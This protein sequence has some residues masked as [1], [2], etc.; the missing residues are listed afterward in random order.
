MP[1][2]GKKFKLFK[3]CKE[4]NV[5][6]DTIESFLKDKGVKVSGPN[7]SISAE[8]HDEILDNFAREKEIADKLHLR[9]TQTDSDEDVQEGELQADKVV[10]KSEYIQNIERSIEERIESMKK[11]EEEPEEE[12]EKISGKKAEDIE[13]EKSELENELESQKVFEQA[14]EIIDEKPTDGKA[15]DSIEEK[16]AKPKKEKIRTIDLDKIGKIAATPEP[17][18]KKSETEEKLS[19]KKDKTKKKEKTGAKEAEDTKEAKRRKALE[20]IRKDEK[21]RKHFLKSGDVD[22]LDSASRQRQRKQKKKSVDQKEVQ[23][24][25]KKTLAS[26]DEKLRKTKKRKKIKDET[27]EEIEQNVI[28]ASEFISANDLANLMDVPVGEIIKKCLELGLVVSINQ[29]LDIDTIELL[30]GE[31]DYTVLKEEEYASDLIEELETDDHDMEDDEWRPP[32][33]TIMGHVDHGKTSLLDF[34]RN[35]NVV[36]GESGGITQHIGAYVVEKDGKKI[37]FLDTPGHEAFTAMRARGAQVTDIVILVVAADDDVMPQT[38]EA[39]DHV[40][41]AGVKM[42]I[43]INKTDRP[44]AN[45]ERI[46][47]QLAERNILVEDWGGEYQCALIS[48]KTGQG[49]DELLEKVLIESELLDL[50]A[51]SKKK[52]KGTVIESLLDKG[53]G[54]ISTILVQNGTLKIG[55]PFIAGQYSGKVRALLDDKDQRVKTAHPSQPVQVLGFDGL[56]QAGDT[57]FVMSDE[58]TVKEI[59]SRRQRIKREQDYRQVKLRTLDQ[60]SENIKSGGVKELRIIVKADVD[61]SAEALADSLIKISKKEV[62]V[63]VI[64]KAVGPISESDVLLAAASDAI[65][66]GFHV[67][68]N[69]KAKELAQQEDIEIRNYR[70]VYDA[71]NDVRLALEGMLETEKREEVTGM[72][73]IRETFKIS[74][75][76]TIAGCHVKSGKISRNSK[77]RL[78]R[79]DVNVY[80]GLLTSLKRF[81]EDVKEVSSGFECGLQIQN[82]N[83]IKVG[84]MIEAFEIVEHKR[85]LDA[86]L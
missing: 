26:I 70:V 57:F 53:K 72:V 24:T 86:A 39:I 34:I 12:P 17:V 31:W 56:P 79:D 10:E 11:K 25:V 67:R 5:G 71:I 23:Q 54:V 52:A 6:I 65:I 69:V 33:I 9:K 21:K 73:E 50:K 68:P 62:A 76:G 44:E 78:I 7:T 18:K 66:I 80:E 14:K 64:R 83:D 20:M 45:P 38:I 74:R 2:A 29:R 4:L 60:I 3:V 28:Y 37:T 35:A 58:Q 61:G 32:I 81:K 41:A 42:I 55:D 8:I 46:K 85:T 27:G 13:A 82:Y 84:D 59:S 75:L 16:D 15:D 49:I 43:A 48:A 30:A 19:D 22:K 77:I 1:V 40:S 47:Q 36:G 63:D 51:N